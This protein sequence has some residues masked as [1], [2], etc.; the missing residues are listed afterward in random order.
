MPGP[1]RYYASRNTRIGGKFYSAGAQ[2]DVSEWSP[3]SLHRALD[4]GQ[5]AV[6]LAPT[7]TPTGGPGGYLHV[8][9]APATQWDIDHSLGYDPAG[10]VVTDS[11]GFTAMGWGLVYTAPGA[12]VRLTFDIPCAGTARLS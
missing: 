12:S 9:A 8:Q 7:G 6:D 3:S 10:I 1:L 11:D 5:L 2:V 4:R